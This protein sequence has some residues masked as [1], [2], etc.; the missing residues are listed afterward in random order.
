MKNS[1]YRSRHRRQWFR[2]FVDASLPQLNQ[3]WAELKW[4]A[5]HLLFWR[6]T[7]F[8]VHRAINFISLFKCCRV[9]RNL[10]IDNVVLHACVHCT[11]YCTVSGTE[12][13]KSHHKTLCGGGAIVR[14][15]HMKYETNH[16]NCMFTREIKL[17]P[18][19]TAQW[20]VQGV[21]A[22]HRCSQIIQQKQQQIRTSSFTYNVG[23]FSIQF[24]QQQQQQ[25]QQTPTKTKCVKFHLIAFATAERPNNLLFRLKLHRRRR[26]KRR[27]FD[28]CAVDATAFRHPFRTNY[29]I[30]C[31]PIQNALAAREQIINYGV[32]FQCFFFCFF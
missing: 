17:C 3:K 4:N 23:A 27:A 18:V 16:R 5:R 8:S 30:I 29:L 24:S 14:D 32:Q 1:R 9:R 20:C 21:N 6:S 31:Y 15:K 10:I 28:T 7:M 12:K 25:Q 11:L 22:G 2:F 19:F 26:K 13:N